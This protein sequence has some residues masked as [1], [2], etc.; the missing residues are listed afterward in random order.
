MGLGLGQRL[1]CRQAIHG[2][3][4]VNRPP[5]SSGNKPQA[6]ISAEGLLHSSG[7]RGRDSEGQLHRLR[8]AGSPPQQIRVID[9]R[10]LASVIKIL[11]IM[12]YKYGGDETVA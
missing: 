6:A 5:I 11:T 1:P 2:L 7:T 12:N 8:R 3:K 4:P 9:K 10:Y